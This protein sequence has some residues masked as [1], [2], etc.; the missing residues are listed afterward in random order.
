MTARSL[1]PP[2]RL[3]SIAGGVASLT[4]SGPSEPPPADVSA[5][6]AE[7]ANT[8]MLR[9]A[10]ELDDATLHLRNN[11]FEAGVIKFRSQGDPAAALAHERLL[12][13]NRGSDWLSQE[14]LLLWKRVLKRI[15]L[16][17][18]SLVALIEPGSCFA[19][20]LAEILF[21]ADRSYMAEGP[22]EDSNRPEAAI[23]LTDANFGLYPMSNGLSPRPAFW[24]SRKA[25]M[26]RKPRRAFRLPLA[27]LTA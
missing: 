3:L 16:T 23:T 4:I 9:C 19:G 10:R 14:I 26:R 21:A 20:T 27:M 22:F 7:G 25:S 2:S 11:E 1:I 12:L 17:S 13:D 5:L 15:D 8:W 6:H 18:R 24:E